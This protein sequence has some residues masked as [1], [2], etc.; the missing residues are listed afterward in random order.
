ML[1][2]VA[3]AANLWSTSSPVEMPASA[4]TAAAMA[5]AP[6]ADLSRYSRTTAN[7]WEKDS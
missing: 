6:R 3:W 4:V 5:R 1:R 2:A 7:A